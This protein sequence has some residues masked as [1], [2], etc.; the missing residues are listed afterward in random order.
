M[1]KSNENEFTQKD[2]QTKNEKFWSLVIKVYFEPYLEQK[3]QRNT[4]M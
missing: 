3:M 1:K 2:S 4:G